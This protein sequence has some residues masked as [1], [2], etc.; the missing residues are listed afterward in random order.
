MTRL[1]ATHPTLRKL[2]LRSNA[3]LDQEAMDQMLLAERQRELKRKQAGLPKDLT[4]IL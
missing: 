1:V 2:Q 3:A 4:L